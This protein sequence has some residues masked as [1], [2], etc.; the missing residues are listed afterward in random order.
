MIDRYY[1]MAI[2]L[3]L[4]VGFVGGAVF[5]TARLPA[6]LSQVTEQSRPSEAENKRHLAHLK[7][8]V[9]KNPDNV[10][11]WLKLGEAHS[12]VGNLAEAITAYEK[13]L[14]LAPNTPDVFAE[15]GDLFRRSK[16]PA[17]ALATFEQALATD[18]NHVMALVG[19]GIVLFHD[20][21]D[22]AAA[23]QAWQKVA[24]LRPNFTVSTGQTIQQLLANVL[25]SGEQSRPQGGDDS[26]KE[27]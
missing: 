11:A 12:D 18:P 5:T 1:V 2:V 10:E 8:E 21:G 24:D 23:A 3:A 4:S 25:E 19:K 16:Q 22:K 9:A 26:D 15:L 7:E 6:I 13:I 20:M 27:R 17:K 14:S